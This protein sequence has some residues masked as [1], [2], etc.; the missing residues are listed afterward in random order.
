M[1]RP[2][3]SVFITTQDGYTRDGSAYPYRLFRERAFWRLVMRRITK[4]PEPPP[5]PTPAK[6]RVVD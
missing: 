1:G 4:R 5:K 3:P 6:L 2:R